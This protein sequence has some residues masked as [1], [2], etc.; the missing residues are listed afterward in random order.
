MAGQQYCVCQSH[1]NLNSTSR[2]LHT[3][4]HASKYSQT[5]PPRLN[6]ITILSNSK[7]KFSVFSTRQRKICRDT[8]ELIHKYHHY[9]YSAQCR[10]T[11]ETQISK[12][13]HGCNCDQEDKSDMARHYLKN[14]FKQPRYHHCNLEGWNTT[15]R[16][17]L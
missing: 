13:D 10:R 2:P 6:V 5:F 14:L 8:I 9:Q 1:C 15:S 11:G 16:D 4:A 12:V 3:L 17:S 7:N